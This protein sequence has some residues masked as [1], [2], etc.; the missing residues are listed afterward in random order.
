MQRSQH[1]IS[2][3]RFALL[4]YHLR[5]LGLGP[6]QSMPGRKQLKQTVKFLIE[7]CTRSAEL[8]IDRADRAFLFGWQRFGL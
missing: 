6:A 4:K 2:L 1:G 8:L 7:F 3:S 5:L